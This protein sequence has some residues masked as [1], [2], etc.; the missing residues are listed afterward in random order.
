MSHERPISQ[1][2]GWGWMMTVTIVDFG[3][4][5]L[6]SVARKLGRLGANPVVTSDPEQV[7][8]AGKIVLPGVGHFGKAMANLRTSGLAAALEEAVA[9]R[10]ARLLGIC[11]GMQLLAR[12]G[13]E[14][15]TEG[16]GWIDAEVVRFRVNDN[17]HF[18][19]PHMGWNGLRIRR[20]DPLLKMLGD[21]STFYF[22]HSYHLVCRDPS[23]V[24]CETQYDYLFPSVVARGH[25][26][27][28]QFHPEKSHDDGDV[29]LTNFVAC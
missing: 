29:L 7:R 19:V 26:F 12:H 24:L 10:G 5:N 17:H 27:G 15:D 4:G 16:L 18:K 2:A 13:E 14:G 25:V 28:V 21:W 9:R 20:E 11:L 1:V 23:D 8:C 6:Q 22:A 3:M